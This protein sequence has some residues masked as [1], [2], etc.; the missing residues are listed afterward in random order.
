M[1]EQ[2]QP[3]ESRTVYPEGE[4][5]KVTATFYSVEEREGS[6][7]PLVA[8][9][10]G[11]SY[12]REEDQKEATLFAQW[13]DLQ[14]QFRQVASPEALRLEDAL[15]DVQNEME[16]HRL[17]VIERQLLDR[18]PQHKAVIQRCVF[19]DEH[20]GLYTDEMSRHYNC[21]LP[22]ARVEA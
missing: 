15:E 14:A 6:K 13:E 3:Q 10:D 1:A 11:V 2:E 8:V 12:R 19:P 7:A 16:A 17:A 5:C 20:P 4:P 22:P 9:I 21:I 18:L